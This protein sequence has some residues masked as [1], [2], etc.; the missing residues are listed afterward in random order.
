MTRRTWATSSINL[1]ESP[2]HAYYHAALVYLTDVDDTGAQTRDHIT[3]VSCRHHHRSYKAARVCAAKIARR[4]GWA[5]PRC[6]ICDAAYD[7]PRH[8]AI[9][10]GWSAKTSGDLASPLVCAD[11]MIRL[12]DG[13]LSGF[14][15]AASTRR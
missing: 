1:R 10:R 9:R 11:C 8:D 7:G 5:R 2:H 3:T 6:T 13:V 4:Y 15:L 12:L 14:G